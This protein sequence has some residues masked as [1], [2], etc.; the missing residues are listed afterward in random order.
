MKYTDRYIQTLVHA[1]V[2]L[3]HAEKLRNRSVLITGGGGLI[4]S[5]IADFLLVLN[6]TAGLNIHVYV[7]DRNQAQTNERLG[8]WIS[9]KDLTILLHDI[10]QPLPEEFEFDYIIHGASFAAPA[11]FNQVPVEVMLA[12]I[13]GMRNVLEYARQHQSQRVLYISSSEVYG[14]KHNSELYDESQYFGI[15][16]LNPRSCYPMS[17]RA[18]ETLCVSY[19]KE[20]GTDSVIVRP[21][22]IYGPTANKKDNRAATQFLADAAAGRDII[23]KSAGMQLRSYC[24]VID[25]VTA[26]L[27]VLLNGESGQA[28]NIS[29]PDS[30][31][32]I[33]DLAE[34]IARQA[35]VN[36]IFE[37]PTDTEKASYN[38][39]DNS[40]LTSDKLISIG[41]KGLY[42]LEA[43]VKEALQAI[44]EDSGNS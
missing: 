14:P 31:V 24:Y 2:S 41:W 5:M 34:C 37:N 9:R 32:T 22:H 20:Y 43:G 10:S 39:M 11:A 29:N 3:K 26:I 35:G 36:V 23:M 19:L 42:N 4:C 1:Q 8:K 44:E 17:K 21:G 18:A 38:M 7:S 40:A 16:T 13:V 27:C 12:N 30:V 25:C 28:Y 6:D 33:R 15:D